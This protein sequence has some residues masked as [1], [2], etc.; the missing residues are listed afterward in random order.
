ME[1]LAA[2]AESG[3]LGLLL[4]ISIIAIVYLY[5]KIDSLQ[6]Q[7]IRDL[8]ES[9]VNLLKPIEGIKQS[10]DLILTLLEQT[11]KIM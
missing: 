10:A 2:L 6:E 1:F 3:T 4:V 11:K 5:R 7:R 9:Q 8:K